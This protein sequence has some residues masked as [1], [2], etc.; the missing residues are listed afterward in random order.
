MLRAPRTVQ[1]QWR[2][3]SGFRRE[4]ISEQLFDILLEHPHQRLTGDE[5]VIER[6]GRPLKPLLSRR[7]TLPRRPSLAEGFGFACSHGGPGDLDRKD[8]GRAVFQHGGAFEARETSST[9]VGSQ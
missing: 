9:A 4:R 6:F 2:H 7:A 5:D 3:P 1:C 8:G